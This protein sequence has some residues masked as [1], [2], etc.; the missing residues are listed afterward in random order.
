VKIDNTFFKTYA[1][2]EKW[3]WKKIKANFTSENL[4]FFEVFRVGYFLDNKTLKNANFPPFGDWK[5]YSSIPSNK[6]K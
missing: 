5:N 6:Q 2:L 3:L 4:D 1:L